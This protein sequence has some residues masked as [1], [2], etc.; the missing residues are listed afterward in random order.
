M[1]TVVKKGE[2]V[3]GT[4][5]GRGS[6]L[7]NPYDFKDSTH[8]QVKFRVNSKEEAINCFEEHLKKSI[9]DGDPNICNAIRNLQIKHFRGEKVNVVCFCAPDACHGDIIKKHV[10][11]SKHITNW[12]SNMRRFDEPLTYQGVN[13][14][15]SEN[16]FQAMKTKDLGIREQIALMNPYKSKTFARTVDLR[17][18]WQEIKIN[19]MRYALRHKFSEH[20]RWGRFLKESKEE[21]IEFNNWGDEFWG[22]DIF[23]ENGANHLGKLLTEI[24]NEI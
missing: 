17:E 5:V 9:L 21:L 15:T 23:S 6:P 10:E 24:R 4:Y 14:W 7:G 1:I 16:F 3:T 11:A 8:P 12:F 13:Y 20:T 2:G 18:D 19:V 22:V